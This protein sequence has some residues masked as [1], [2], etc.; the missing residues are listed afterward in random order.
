MSGRVYLRLK[1]N[2]EDIKGESSVNTIG[3][4]DVSTLI[5]CDAYNESCKTAQEAGSMTPT[6]TRLYEPITIRKAVDSSS[7]LLMRALTDTEP[8]EGEFLF[9]RPAKASGKQEKF[10]TVTISDA[11][12][13]SVKRFLPDE[14]SVG[15]TASDVSGAGKPPMEEVAF[16][17]GKIS[18]KHEVGKTE[19][20]DHWQEQ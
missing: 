11:R 14:A 9:F 19:H 2:K 16:V 10:F 18:W 15:A 3:G 5:E 4:E 6:G 1:A 12:V 8:C 17:F 7:P 13:C 20:D